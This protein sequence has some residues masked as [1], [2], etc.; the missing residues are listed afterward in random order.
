MARN[1]SSFPLSPTAPPRKSRGEIE[2]IP[3][4]K[5]EWVRERDIMVDGAKA[6]ISDIAAIDAVE[7]IQRAPVM[8]SNVLPMDPNDISGGP[9]GSRL[10]R[11]GL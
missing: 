4:L 3:G 5:V 11:H 9:A 7:W 10:Q 2:R 1:V 6:R 8:V